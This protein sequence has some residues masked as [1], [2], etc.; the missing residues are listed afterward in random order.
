MINAQHI[1]DTIRDAIG[2]CHPDEDQRVVGHLRMDKGKT[3]PVRG[4]QAVFDILPRSN[5]VNRLMLG[6]GFQQC[7]RCVPGDPTQF[8][9]THIK[10]RRQQV[11][12]FS[13]KR[14]KPWVISADLA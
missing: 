10:P 7:R 13:I 14:A 2:E 6:E 8:E 9:E 5:S 12:E 1:I 11:L 3:T 4:R